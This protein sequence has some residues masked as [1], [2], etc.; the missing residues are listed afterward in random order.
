MNKENLVVGID[1]SNLREGG[2]I[3]HLVELLSVARPLEH[4]VT[5]VIVF[6]GSHIL[7]TL[8]DQ[9]WL[10]K[11]FVPELDRNLLFRLYWQRFKFVSQARSQGCS[12]LFA[13]G[14]SYFGAFE[15]AVTMSRN[16]LPFESAEMG[17]YGWS[18]R[19]IRLILLRMGQTKSFK[20]AA[21]I[22]FLTK[23]AQSAILE[24][25]GPLRGNVTQIPHGL[26]ARFR[27]NPRP[28]LPI[29]EYD[30][31]RPFRLLYVSTVDE[32]KHQW[33][34]IEAVAQLRQ[35]GLPVKLDLV[36]SAYPPSLRRLKKSISF[37]DPN[38]SWAKYHGALPHEELRN[39]YI[40]AD[41]G[42]FASSCENMP[43][44][45][46]EKMAAGLP[47]ACAKRGPTPEILGQSGIYFD[48]ESPADISRSIRQLIDSPSLRLENAKFN[49]NLANKYSWDQCA[50]DTFDF[51]RRNACQEKPEQ[52]P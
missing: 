1:A 32:Y 50:A 16:M 2:G 33:N 31:E 48:P 25:T 8:A 5:Q 19:R 18:A 11:C 52:K 47:I 15:P 45:L 43:N 36:G 28:Q 24:L 38:Q 9:P 27:S 10:V 51:L 22:I 21:G 3:T 29:S 30:M 7:N 40:G 49:F 17:R 41:L 34:V 44:I 13:P 37:W 4:G 14:G 12:L 35:S 46:L 20:R 39:I 6:G 26:N 23:Y 42:I